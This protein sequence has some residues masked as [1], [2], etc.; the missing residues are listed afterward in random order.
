MNQAVLLSER[1][2]S[3]LE[4]SR[5]ESIELLRLATALTEDLSKAVCEFNGA[6]RKFSRLSEDIRL[7]MKY[8]AGQLDELFI[9]EVRQGY[10]AL[11]PSLVKSR[12]PEAYCA[13]FERA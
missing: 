8:I 11:T 1:R 4:N 13:W 6:Y 3:Y 2:L 9:L 10:F 5:A 7:K 12:Y